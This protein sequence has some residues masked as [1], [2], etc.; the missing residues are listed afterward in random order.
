M[1]TRSFARTMRRT[2]A[3][4]RAA[5]FLLLSACSSLSAL[6]VSTFERIGPFAVQ[7]I[8]TSTDDDRLASQ[9]RCAPASMRRET[10]AHRIFRPLLQFLFHGS[11]RLFV[12]EDAGKRIC[13]LV[14]VALS[15]HSAAWCSAA[16][17]ALPSSASPAPARSSTP[18]KGSSSARAPP[19]HPFGSSASVP[20]TA[21]S[22]RRAEPRTTGSPRVPRWAAMPADQ[23]GAARAAAERPVAL[24]THIYYR[25]G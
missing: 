25:I 12:C 19:H 21:R 15:L 8:N 16:Y 10:L 6:L 4:L 5:R 14:A 20:T 3:A 17:C 18:G 9:N 13:E 2:A 11:F 7:R 23:Q 1:L 24:N 22:S